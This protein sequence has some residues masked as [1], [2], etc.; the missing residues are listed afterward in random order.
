M[1]TVLALSTA[2]APAF[3]EPFAAVTDMPSDIH[4]GRDLLQIAVIGGGD[5]TCGDANEPCCP[6]SACN[7]GTLTC[8]SIFNRCQPCGS[9]L[10]PACT[11][12]GVAP[13]G[14]GLRAFSGFCVTNIGAG[15]VTGPTPTPTPPPTPPGQYGGTPPPPPVAPPPVTPPP[16]ETPRGICICTGTADCDCSTTSCGAVGES[17]CSAR[18][19]VFTI[20]ICTSGACDGGVCAAQ[21][22]GGCGGGVALGNSCVSF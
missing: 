16:T 19:A 1:A 17:C 13:C 2:V 8:R 4:N 22:G 20:N 11:A 14:A 7:S 9:R 5:G 3:A 12:A 15:P 21:P 10:Q 6:G 18:F